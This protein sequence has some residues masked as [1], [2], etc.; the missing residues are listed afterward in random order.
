M[1]FKAGD[2]VEVRS[3][4]EIL[5]TLD[6]LGRLDG[7]PFMPQML[8]YCGRRLRVLSRATKTCDTVSGD[9]KG[10]QLPDAVHLELRCDGRDHAGCQAGCLL[11][12]KTAWLRPVDAAAKSDRISPQPV[13]SARVASSG[14]GCTE[15]DLGRATR[16]PSEAGDDRVRYACQATELLT[17]TRPLKWWDVRQYAETWS[18]GNHTAG[19]VARGLAFLA[20]TYGLLANRRVAGQPARWLYDRIQALRGRRA[21]PHRFGLVPDGAETPRR[22]LGLQPGDLVRIRSH[23]EILATLDGKGSNRGLAF[24]A[25]L[26]PYCGSVHRVSARVE[27]FVDEKT[28]VLRTLKTPAVILENVYCK[29]LYSG[30]RMFCPRA[31]HLWWRESW[32]ERVDASGGQGTSPARD[33]ALQ[34]TVEPPAKAVPA[35]RGGG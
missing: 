20:F 33:R 18:S 32:L 9:Y 3:R 29:A 21:F 16:K 23:A 14:L 17:Y 27:R 22:D 7:L 11:F 24:D 26:V 10:L 12:W 4:A 15:E 19:Q 8:D 30:Q 2:W 34:P 25:E 35:H 5:A 1:T 13:D 28:G 31:I 6:R